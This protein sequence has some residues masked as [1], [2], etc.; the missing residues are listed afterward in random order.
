[1]NVFFRSVPILSTDENT[2]FSGCSGSGVRSL[3]TCGR[4][5]MSYRRCYRY[6]SNRLIDLVPT[7]NIPPPHPH[8]LSSFRHNRVSPSVRRFAPFRS[9]RP[10]DAA[11]LEVRLPD[12]HLSADCRELSRHRR[13]SSVA[14]NASTSLLISFPQI[15]HPCNTSIAFAIFSIRLSTNGRRTK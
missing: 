10:L 11:R 7:P 6:R 12:R 13:A 14:D 5:Q 9:R 8:P 15:P 4:L 1:M 2:C 3:L